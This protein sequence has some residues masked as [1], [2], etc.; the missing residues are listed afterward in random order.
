MRAP[1]RNA[2][3]SQRPRRSAIG[4][5]KALGG[6]VHVAIRRRSSGSGDAGDV[7]RKDQ[8]ARLERELKILA[9]KNISA[10]F[11]IVWDFRQLGSPARHPGQ[12]RGSGVGTMV[13]VCARSFQRVP[14]AL[15]PALRAVHRP[16]SQRV[17][18]YRYRP[19]PG[20]ARRTSSTT[21]ARSTGT[22]RRSSRSER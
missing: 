13:G 21:C 2:T 22:W 12:R 1:G 4:A 7:S 10:Y 16:R 20:R 17:P 6:G 19:V 14:G 8:T 3:R 5:A 9:D 11:L 15:R 18:R